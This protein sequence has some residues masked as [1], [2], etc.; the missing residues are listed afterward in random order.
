MGEEDEPFYL[1]YLPQTRT[2]CC[3]LYL[4]FLEL[5]LPLIPMKALLRLYCLNGLVPPDWH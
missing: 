1:D 4:W 3:G 2:S 5:A